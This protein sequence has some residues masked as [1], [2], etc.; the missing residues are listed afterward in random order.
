MMIYD[1]W[2]RKKGN[3]HY[4]Y[5]LSHYSFLDR[6]TWKWHIVDCHSTDIIRKRNLQFIHRVRSRTVSRCNSV[7]YINRGFDK[8]L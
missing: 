8:H 2:K 5:T 4:C 7:R 3:M 1:K 6:L